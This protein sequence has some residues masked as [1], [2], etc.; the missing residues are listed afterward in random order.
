MF[1]NR[2]HKNFGAG[3]Q[4]GNCI[5]PQCGYSEI[6]QQGISCRTKKCPKCGATLQSEGATGSKLPSQNEQQ[7]AT[8]TQS[9]KEPKKEIP[10]PTV[11][12]SIC[13]GCGKCIEICPQ[14]TIIMENN[15]AKII[16]ADCKKCRKCVKICP[17]NA[18]Q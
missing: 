2:R 3:M 12:E 13:I 17:V 14:Q 16:E 5:C 8:K 11:D 15:K 6:H 10:F 7:S 18:I 4:R 9:R 1:G